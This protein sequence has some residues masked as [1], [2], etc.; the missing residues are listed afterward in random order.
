M[1]EK[2][3]VPDDA[4]I[5]ISTSSSTKELSQIVKQLLLEEND[6]QKLQNELKSKKLTFMIN[7]TF[8]TLTLQDLLDQLSISNEKTV[9]I[10]YLFALEKPK[11]KQSTP[12]DEWISV[13]SNLTHIVNEKAKSYAVG[14]FNGDVKLFNARHDE[15]LS[16]S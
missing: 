12:Q 1:P 15:I 7:N 11:H 3:K 13:I 8:L 6:D 2:Y 10:Y 4:V 14:F 9:E 5:S 16:V